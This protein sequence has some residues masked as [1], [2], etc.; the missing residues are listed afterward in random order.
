VNAVEHIVEAYFRICRKCFVMP[1]VKIEGGNN[2]QFDLLAVD[3]NKGYQYHVES[4]VTHQENWCPDTKKLRT[5]FNMKFLGHPKEKTGENTDFAKGK[6]YKAQLWRAYRSV[7][8]KPDKV[9]RIWCCWDVTDGENLSSFLEEYRVET[10]LAVKVLRFPDQ[11]LASLL[12]AVATSNY[13]DEVLRT[14][15][16]FRQYLNRL[17]DKGKE[18]I[19]EGLQLT[20]VLKKLL[21][22]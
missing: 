1:D 22:W 11:V 7:G 13:D 6:I 4:S 20:E 3:L 21:K 10:D 9:Q 12:K 5:N 16:L 15:S 14:M 8:F 19:N 2:R 18:D 17:L